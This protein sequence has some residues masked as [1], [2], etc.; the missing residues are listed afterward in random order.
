MVFIVQNKGKLNTKGILT[1][2]DR[3]SNRSETQFLTDLF[4]QDN[5]TPAS[6]ESAEQPV[7]SIATRPEF[8]LA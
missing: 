4:L 6:S 8:H 2:Y 7:Y 1:K 3:A 5:S